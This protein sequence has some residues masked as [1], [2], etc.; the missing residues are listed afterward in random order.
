MKP[1]LSAAG[2]LLLCGCDGGSEKYSRSGDYSI[3]APASASAR[4]VA[5]LWWGMLSFSTIV[6]AAVVGIF[7]YA[8]KRGREPATEDKAQRHYRYWLLGGGLLL[9]TLS[10]VVLLA[11]G[12]PVGHRM[13]PLPLEGE[14]TLQIEVTG[15]Q[16]W[17]EVHYPNGSINLK[18]ELHIPVDTPV[19]IHLTSADVVHAFWVPRLGGKLDL[20]PG[21]V[22]ILRL[23]ADQPG[24]YHGQCAEFCGTGHARMHFTV[25]VHSREAFERWRQEAI[26]HD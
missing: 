2:L 24:T 8:M 1:A 4:E 9:P 5:W 7:L 19:D 21:R 3:L 25:T 12:I 18:D 6:L 26:R 11:F 14:K 23:H 15:H 13:M 16:W 22:N 10:I 17:W 20:L